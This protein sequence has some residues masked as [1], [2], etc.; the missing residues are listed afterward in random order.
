M[1]PPLPQNSESLPANFPF[2]D[3]LD[4][5][6]EEDITNMLS[7]YDQE[8]TMPDMSGFLM[9]MFGEWTAK[10]FEDGLGL[11]NNINYSIK[12]GVSSYMS[13]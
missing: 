5:F 13:S 10:G 7:G 9:S 4:I 1:F 2:E 3:E 11:N 6:H 8:Q 12:E